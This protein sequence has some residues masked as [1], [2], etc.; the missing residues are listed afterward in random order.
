M[1]RAY[2]SGE[3]LKAPKKMLKGLFQL[4]LKIDLLFFPQIPPTSL[5]Q[6]EYFKG[7]VKVKQI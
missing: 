7:R 4:Y 6:E 2:K 3:V 5:E 1:P